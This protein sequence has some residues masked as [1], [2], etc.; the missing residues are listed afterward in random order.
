MIRESIRRRLRAPSRNHIA[1]DVD[2]LR[3]LTYPDYKGFIKRKSNRTPKEVTLR[4]YW[5]YVERLQA[6]L[7]RQ[8]DLPLETALNRYLLELDDYG[9]NTRIVV[10]SALNWAFRALHL[11]DVDGDPLRYPVPAKEVHHRKPVVSAQG[12]R[13]LEPLI[14]ARTNPREYACI[15]VLRDSGLRP[16]DVVSIRL[17]ELRLHDGAPRIEETTQKAGVPVYSRITRK[18]AAILAQYLAHYRPRT[19]LFESAPGKPYWRAWPWWILTQKC[20]LDGKGD[21]SRVTP[22]IFRRTLATRWRGDLKGLLAQGGWKDV[23]TPQLH[24]QQHRTSQHDLDYDALMEPE[25]GRKTREVDD[26]AAYR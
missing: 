14:R 4:R 1:H 8:G 16:S 5:G 24:Y 3:N 22:R 13:E 9:T 18:T 11:K 19:Y 17:E 7:G 21:S 6:W 2:E 20:G 26:D 23:K 12:W 25:E 10:H 15:R